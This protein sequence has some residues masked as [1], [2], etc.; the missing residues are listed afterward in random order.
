M[1]EAKRNVCI[2]STVTRIRCKG[3]DLD[4]ALQEAFKRNAID[5]ETV[6]PNEVIGLCGDIEQALNGVWPKHESVKQLNLFV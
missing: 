3:T 4:T 5:P 6:T 2:A 1:K